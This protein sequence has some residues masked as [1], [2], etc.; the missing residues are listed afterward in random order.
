MEGWRRRVSNLLVH[1]VER[2]FVLL[3]T[4]SD[5]I[6]RLN[7]TASLIWRYLDEAD[8]PEDIAGRLVGEYDVEWHAALEDVHA[9]V[10]QLAKLTL[11]VPDRA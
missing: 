11:V 1:E 5:R 2:E 10:G 8:S 4:D 6:H 7:R 9:A 3:D